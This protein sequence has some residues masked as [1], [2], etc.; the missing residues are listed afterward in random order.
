MI[1][2]LGTVTPCL[3]SAPGCNPCPAFVQ[4][5]SGVRHGSDAREDACFRAVLAPQSPPHHC[6][7]VCCRPTAALV[8][9][10]SVEL[11]PLPRAAPVVSLTVVD[12]AAKVVPAQ[13]QGVLCLGLGPSIDMMVALPAHSMPKTIPCRQV[14]ILAL[15]ISRFADRLDSV[16]DSVSDMIGCGQ[17]T[18]SRAFTMVRMLAPGAFTSCTHATPTAPCMRC[19]LLLAQYQ[20]VAMVAQHRTRNAPRQDGTLCR[21]RLRRRF[22]NVAGKVV[23]NPSITPTGLDNLSLL[24]QRCTRQAPS[25]VGRVRLQG[26]GPSVGQ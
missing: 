24:S 21:S 8:R 13:L 4:P 11:A 25:K 6:S 16:D 3:A 5:M 19:Q 26:K 7:H 14:S 15:I 23:T 18:P 1:H 9:C 2:T 17:A 10:L 20:V 12:M 22:Q